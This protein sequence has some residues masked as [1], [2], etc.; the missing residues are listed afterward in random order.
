M[1]KSLFAIAATTA[2]VGAAHAQSS[3]TV[4]GILDIGYTGANSRLQASNTQAT[5]NYASQS[6]YQQ[7]VLS[8]QQGY[9]GQSAEQT[10]RLGFRGTEDLGGGNTAFFTIETG[11]TPSDRTAT[12]VSTFNNR[13]AFVGLGNKSLGN[14][15][16]G[17]QYQP[18]HIAIANSDPGQQNNMAGG[19]IYTGCADSQTTGCWGGNTAAYQSR[20]DNSVSYVSPV[21]AGFKLSAFGVY[22]AQNATTI[23]STAANSGNIATGGTT[24]STGWSLGL[25]YTI[26]KAYLTANYSSFKQITSTT[27]QTAYGTTTAVAGASN[28][29]SWVLWTASTGTAVNTLENTMYF[30][31]TYD[32]GILKAY[33]QYINRKASDTANSSLYQQRSAQQIGVRSFV[34][35]TVEAWAM[36]GNGSFTPYGNSQQSAPMNTWQV[37]SN[38]WLSKRTNFYAI[39]G[40]YN[41]STRNYIATTSA[42]AQSNGTASANVSTYAVGV[43][44]TF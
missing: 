39:Y 24:N 38:Y 11:L 5:P 37:G 34:T 15:S 13:Q 21:T 27:N 44:H 9:I 35:K 42:G 25:D 29:G 26:Q 2:F 16:V 19:I 4:Y 20:F 14:L 40:A 3:V 1:K 28:T 30:A 7:G 23:N 17:T 10:S 8:T 12:T 41:Q 22:N 31:G 18:I 6:A 33:V 43:R 32:F 36:G